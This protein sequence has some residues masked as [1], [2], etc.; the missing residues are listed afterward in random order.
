MMHGKNLTGYSIRKEINVFQKSVARKNNIV[1]RFEQSTYLQTT[2]K[3]RNI[4]GYGLKAMLFLC[5][6]N[7]IFPIFFSQLQAIVRYKVMQDD[8]SNFVNPFLLLET[9]QKIFC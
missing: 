8:S 1:T 7:L 4:N 5:N 9:A 6:F 2:I 3:K